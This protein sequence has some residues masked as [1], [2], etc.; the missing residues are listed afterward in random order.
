MPFVPPAAPLAAALLP[1]LAAVDG[2][3]DAPPLRLQ[4]PPPEGDET[5]DD[6]DEDEQRRQ[7]GMAADEDR[8]EELVEHGG[9]H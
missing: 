4:A 2:A 5:A 7:V 8:P 6:A 3:V 1:A 9:G